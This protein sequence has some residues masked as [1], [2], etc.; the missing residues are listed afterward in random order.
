MMVQSKSKYGV[1]LTLHVHEGEDVVTITWPDDDE[2]EHTE[3]ELLDYL[4]VFQFGLD[5]LRA[6]KAAKKAEKK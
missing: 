2:S 3:E 1:A 4:R 6:N 5:V